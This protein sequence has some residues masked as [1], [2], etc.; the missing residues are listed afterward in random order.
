MSP[1]L[2][3]HQLLNVNVTTKLGYLLA[4]VVLIICGCDVALFIFVDLIVLVHLNLPLSI[5]LNYL[6]LILLF[7]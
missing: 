7:P 3:G 1:S 2:R 4:S 6:K 5:L